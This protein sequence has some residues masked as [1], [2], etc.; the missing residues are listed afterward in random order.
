MDSHHP[1]VC[2]EIERRVWVRQIC[3]PANALFWTFLIKSAEAEVRYGPIACCKFRKLMIPVD[4]IVIFDLGPCSG[5]WTDQ[6]R[7]IFISLP[8]CRKS[9]QNC[10][11]TCSNHSITITDHGCLRRSC[12]G[13]ICSHFPDL[14]RVT[15][16]RILVR[17]C[18][19]SSFSDRDRQLSTGNRF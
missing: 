5:A 16:S 14:P 13:I 15:F 2:E 18:V 7:I 1:C 8:Q 12:S 9:V 17:Y 19:R 3:V 11:E 6:I 4:L 10:I